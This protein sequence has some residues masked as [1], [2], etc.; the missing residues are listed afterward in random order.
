MKR[1]LPGLALIITTSTHALYWQNNY[2]VSL[3]AGTDDNYFL[4]STNEIDT[5]FSKLSLFASADGADQQNKG[6]YR[7]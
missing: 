2:G 4:T 3:E 5:N 7:F 6:E 1:F